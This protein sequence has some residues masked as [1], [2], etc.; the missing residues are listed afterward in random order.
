MTTPPDSAPDQ[1]IKESSPVKNVAAESSGSAKTKSAKAARTSAA[2][3]ARTTPRT[4][5]MMTQYLA[6]KADH[7]NELLFY[8]MGDFYELFFDDAVQASEALDITLTKRGQHLG[9]DIPMCGVPVHA[10]DSYL[11]RL[12]KKGFRVAVCEQTE[13][14][15]EAK[16]RG[17]NSVVRRAVVR[18]VTAG[19]LTEDN[20]LDGRRNNYL[21]ALAQVGGRQV[22]GEWG[23]AWLDLSTGEFSTASVSEAAL[24][25]ELARLDPG[26]LLIEDRAY[27]TNADDPLID[28]AN[29]MTPLPPSST[30]SQSGE[31]RLKSLFAVVALDAFGEFSRAELGAAGALVDYVDLTQKGQAALIRPPVRLQTGSVLAIDSATRRNLEI[32]QSLSGAR[33]SSLLAV[34]D[35]TATGTG[36]RLL[37]QRLNA[38]L[39]DVGEIAAR[40]D[41]VESLLAVAATRA[42]LRNALKTYPDMERALARLTLDRGGPRDLAAIRDGLACTQDIRRVLEGAPDAVSAAFEAGLKRFNGHAELITKLESALAPDLPVFTRDGGFVAKGYDRALDDVVVLRDESRRLTRNLEV[43]YRTETGIM[44]LKVRHNNVLGYFVDVTPTHADKITGQHEKFIHRQTLASAVRFTTVELGELEGKISSA[45]DRALALETEIFKK[46]SKDVRDYGDQILLAAQGVAEVDVA[47]ALAQVA[48]D[49]GY[50]RPEIDATTA[51]NIEGGR[52]PVVEAALK[53]DNQKAFITNDCD[54]G[55]DSNLW[56]VTGPNMAGKSTFLRQNALIVILAQMGSFVPATSAHIGVVDRLFSRV[57]AADDLARGRSTFMVEMVEAAA[58]LNRAGPRSLVILDEIGRGTATFDGLSIAW[59]AIE[60]LHDVNKSRALFATHY[61]EL[62]MLAAKLLRLATWTLRV[63]EWEGSVVFMHDVV[64]GAA[65]RSYGIAVA[66]L[67]GLPSS[68]IARAEIVLQALEN[69]EQGGAVARLADDLPLFS[70]AASEPKAN[71]PR[72]IDE[73]LADLRPDELSPRD[74]L[75]ALYRLKAIFTEGE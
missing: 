54:L 37:S 49:N 35:M 13:D 38:P 36:A 71:A 53:S 62:T 74:A 52:H 4:T 44:S 50:V 65:D 67:A 72:P 64:P 1:N 69:G 5:P 48:H 61:H 66:K 18:I 25:S 3:A 70:V 26:E 47:V 41:V 56:L 59:A 42:D 22:S 21:A 8:R 40:L 16:K 63:K 75:E 19:T 28:W 45:A 51:F 31:R 39:T 43:E 34:I 24:E 46:L 15:A 29:R 9:E 17:S 2:K 11:P 33:D 23:L 14:P 68:A 30:D 58:I 60:H 12:I 10:G 6:I 32:T 27:P 57:G 55:P 73:A 7:P 20:L